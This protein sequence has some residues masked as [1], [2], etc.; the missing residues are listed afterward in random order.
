MESSTPKQFLPIK[1]KPILLHTME[2]FHSCKYKPEIIVVLPKSQL[3]TWDHICSTQK[4]NIKHSIC[5]GGSERFHSVKNGLNRITKNGIVA[6][7]DGVRPLVS[8]K[9]IERTFKLAKEKGSAIPFI[10]VNESVRN[11]EQ[12]NSSSL[13]RKKIA[14]IQT[15]QCFDVA[16]LKNAYKQE[17]STIFTD[18]ASVF[19][20]AGEKLHLCEGNH[21]NIK[22]T[23]PIDIRIVESIL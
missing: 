22:I 20:A 15:P 7:H 18:D 11:I 1:G 16:K 3:E 13:D 23:T 14:L 9:V 5:E 17:Y 21:E 19:E 2:K 10:N 4:I 8:K 6:I 12:S